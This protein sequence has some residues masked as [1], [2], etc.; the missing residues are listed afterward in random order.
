MID[1][2]LISASILK[3]QRCGSPGAGFIGGGTR[4]DVLLCSAILTGLQEQGRYAWQSAPTSSV[5][6]LLDHE[7]RKCN[8]A[9]QPEQERGGKSQAAV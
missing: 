3:A 8:Q 1:S 5:R 4:F 6:S 9:S 7:M 2:F